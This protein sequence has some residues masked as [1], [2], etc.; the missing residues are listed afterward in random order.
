MYFCDL[1]SNP[2]EIFEDE[3]GDR[4]CGQ[5]NRKGNEVP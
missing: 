4:M 1:L 2:K 3:V 5:L